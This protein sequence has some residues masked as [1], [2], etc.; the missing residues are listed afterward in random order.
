[1]LSL[2]RAHVQSLIGELASYK[3]Q[4]GAKKKKKRE[5]AV[6]TTGLP[7]KSCNHCALMTLGKNRVIYHVPGWG[8]SI[9]L[10]GNTVCYGGR[11]IAVLNRG[12]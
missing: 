5:W 6:L 9:L 3:L 4:D 12:I 2:P 10:K 8:N 11:G 1:M 7:G